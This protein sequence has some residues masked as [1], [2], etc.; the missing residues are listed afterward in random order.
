MVQEF[1]TYICTYCNEEY[2]TWNGANRC[3]LKHKELDA[4]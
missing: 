3:E 1:V 2:P 4:A